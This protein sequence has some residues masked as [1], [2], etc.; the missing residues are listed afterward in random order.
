MKRKLIVLILLIQAIGLFAQTD[1]VVL[2]FSHGKIA[3]SGT[4]S[5]EGSG[6]VDCAVRIP[7]AYLA[8][9]DG[10]DLSAVRAGLISRINVDS[11]RV[12]VR[13]S[14]DGANIGETLITRY[15]DPKLLAGWNT[16]KLSSPYRISGT[17]EQLYVGFS[18]HQRATVNVVSMVGDSR[19][20]TS[21]VR[22][23]DN[24]WK[25]VSSNGVLSIEA[26][27]TGQQLPKYDLG[28]MSA[29]AKSY[30][31]ADKEVLRMTAVVHNFGLQPVSGFTLSNI[32][33]GQPSALSASLSDVITSGDEQSVTF[34]LSPTVTSSYDSPWTVSLASL[35][36]ANDE[37]SGNNS[38]VSGYEFMRNVMVEEFTTERC[39][40]CPRVAGWLSTALDST[41]QIRQHVFA[42][43]HHAG[44]Y[45]DYFT[46]PCD[47][48]LTW[49]YNDGEYAPA[50]MIDRRANHEA[51]YQTGKH[52][53]TFCPSD[54]NEIMDV[55]NSE[56][57]ITSN[58]L[59]RMTTSYNADSTELNVSVKC[60]RNNNYTDAYPH[61]MVYLLE[62]NVASK[63]Q[64]GAPA[65]FIHNHV[66]RAYNSSWGD[67]V[68]WNDN[69]FESSY[70]FK[71]GSEFKKS[72]LQV[73]SFIYNYD[74]ADKTDCNVENA[75]RVI[76]G[77]N[78][79]ST[80]IDNIINRRQ[81]VPVS[82]YDVNG[83][84]IMPSHK[85]LTIIKMSDGSVRKQFNR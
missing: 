14:L 40:N 77:S 31:D 17:E 2:G 38:C 73:V 41:E 51:V 47:E 45:T 52:T 59:L 72:D 74:T 75:A 37:Y 22:L 15:T 80:D 82:Y 50:L 84:R 10:C 70:T 56:L 11:V 1:S 34:E 42:A 9:Y 6:W 5:R 18:L 24:T 61:L 48:E 49:L 81:S 30:Y 57:N 32:A 26:E 43:C 21:F 4:I 27:I 25:D 39:L 79:S 29:L 35:N 76:L 13:H 71:V 44:Y 58:A 55:I 66:E 65:S 16:V 64:S 83:C 36:G 3:A 68:I 19:Y 63:N 33:D 85:G 67:P 12:W 54:I 53:A 7:T 69:K 28:I 20:N 23:D 60:L 8:S 62:N 46:Q 78:G